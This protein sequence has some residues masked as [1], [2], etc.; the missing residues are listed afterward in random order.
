VA[1]A[2][3]AVVRLSELT[4][5][6]LADCFA[7][8]VER[9]RNSTREGKPFYTVRFRDAKRT[10]ATV[11]WSDSPLFA[12]CERDWQPGRCYKLRVTLIETEKYGQQLDV[13]Q[14]RLAGDE[15]R[16]DGFDPLDLV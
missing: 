3:P 1:R 5:G 4:P 11:V 14:I 6:R 9:T 2:K 15:D 16:P 7:Q 13:H 8:L 10:L 12:D